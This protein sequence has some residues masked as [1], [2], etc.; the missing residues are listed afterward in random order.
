VRGGARRFAYRLAKELGEVDVD[1]MLGRVTWRQLSEW[2]AF[3][4]LEPF[5]EERDDFRAAQIVQALWNIARDQTKC[6]NGYPL[7]DFVL[8]IG[9]SPWRSV[10]AASTAQTVESQELLIDAWVFGHNEAL[11]AKEARRG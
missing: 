3:E 4:E 10:G 1:A 6:P 11:K 8:K 5:G 9:D 2:M 7:T